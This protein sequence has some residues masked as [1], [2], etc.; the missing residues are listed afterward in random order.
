MFIRSNAF[1]LQVDHIIYADNARTQRL[2]FTYSFKFDRAMD[3]FAVDDTLKNTNGIYMVRYPLHFFPLRM[4]LMSCY[5]CLVTLVRQ[6][7][8]FVSKT[9]NSECI[10]KARVSSLKKLSESWQE[11]TWRRRNLAPSR[12]NLT[13]GF[14]PCATTGLVY[15]A[16]KY[17]P[18]V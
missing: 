15:D 12:S 1:Q 8:V 7:T 6:E 18:N 16:L 17:C 14:T 4:K 3:A 13:P 10:G 2:P 11:V 9:R 5:F